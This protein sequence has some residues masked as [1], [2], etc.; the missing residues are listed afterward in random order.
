MAQRRMPGHGGVSGRSLPL[1]VAYMARKLGHD[2]GEAEDAEGA[3][4][5]AA[6]TAAAA[7]A[8]EQTGDSCGGDSALPPSR[9]GAREGP[10]RIAGQRGDSHRS[11]TL[12]AGGGCMSVRQLRS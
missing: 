12:A 7:A 2:L 9:R 1:G 3:A 6:A 11:A 10:P 4:R 5:Q 8:L